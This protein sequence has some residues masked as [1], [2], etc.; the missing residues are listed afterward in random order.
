MLACT[1]AQSVKDTLHTCT[2]T[3]LHHNTPCVTHINSQYPVYIHTYTHTHT[4]THTH[5]H[6]GSLAGGTRLI[7]SGSGFSSNTN[8]GNM[9][10]IGTHL[11]L[12]CMP[13]PLH[14]TANQIA[15][16]TQSALPFTYERTNTPAQPATSS[17]YPTYGTSRPLNITIVSDGEVASCIGACQFQ[18][19]EDWSHTPR[20]YN[21]APRAVTTGTVITISGV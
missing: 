6:R 16:K 3:P 5:I 11:G 18:Y 13:I 12:Q 7:I 10:Y 20:V 19:H 8:S 9:V 15:C 2:Y 4:H 1:I 14:S 17:Y 21:I